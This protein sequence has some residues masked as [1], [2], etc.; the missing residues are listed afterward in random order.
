[1]TALKTEEHISFKNLRFLKCVKKN[2]CDL[3]ICEKFKSQQLQ[4][5]FDTLE[6]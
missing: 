4:K 6:S 2:L 5:F 3:L 1:M